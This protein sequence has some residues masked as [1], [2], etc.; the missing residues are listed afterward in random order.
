MIRFANAE[1][2]MLVFDHRPWHVNRL[3][4]VVTKWTPFFDSYIVVINRI[5]QWVGVPRLPWEFWDQDSLTELLKPVGTMV[6]VDQNTLLRLKGKFARVYL[7]INITYP[8]PGSLTI[9]REGLSMKVPLIYE[10]LHEVFPLCGGESHQLD[11]CP[12]L[13]AQ[14]KVQVVVQKFEAGITS[15]ISTEPSSSTNSQ[16]P[17]SESWV[18]VFPKKRVRPAFGH[19]HKKMSNLKPKD[20][21]IPTNDPIIPPTQTASAPSNPKGIV[22]ANLTAMKSQDEGLPNAD[23][24]CNTRD[25]I[26]LR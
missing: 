14:K 21:P 15:C 23:K 19:R 6:R 18:T 9:A 22:F 13:P 2:R 4:F 8:I 12:K 25:S 5:D 24:L 1:D 17:P 3:N 16:I 7:N 10:E 26:P 20:P 11:S